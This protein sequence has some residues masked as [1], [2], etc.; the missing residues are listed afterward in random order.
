MT[1]FTIRPA[2]TAYNDAERLIAFFNSQVDYLPTI[3]STDQ[4]T[5]HVDATRA[6]RVHD[7]VSNSEVY[8]RQNFDQQYTRAF[9][10]EVKLAA[11]NEDADLVKLARHDQATQSLWLPVAGLVLEAKSPEYVRSILPEQDNERPFVYLS[12]LI[13]DRRV[14]KFA[15]GAGSALIAHSR[16]QVKETG[17]NRLCVDCYA[18]NNK[19]LT[20]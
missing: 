2:K 7:W 6:K 3:G 19:S 8:E 14:N 13:S 17:L 16:E 9:I 15:K 18:G 4:W 10:A 1:I 20:K 12:Y 11:E 5:E